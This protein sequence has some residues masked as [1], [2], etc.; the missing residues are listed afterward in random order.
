MRV[1]KLNDS[2]MYSAVYVLSMNQGEMLIHVQRM[3][4]GP[5]Y[6]TYIL[7]AQNY[8]YVAHISSL[9]L[10]NAFLRHITPGQWTC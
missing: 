9:E 1:L 3:H 8:F 10:L 4:M 7:S 6:G 2:L 5:I